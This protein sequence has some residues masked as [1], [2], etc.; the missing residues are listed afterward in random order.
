ME[1]YFLD[2]SFGVTCGPTEEF[3]SAVWSE[4]YYETGSFTVHMPKKFF[5]TAIDAEYLR[6]GFG[7]DGECL[8]GRI[9]N[10]RLTSSDGGE[11][12]ISG[13]MLE[14]LLGGRVMY[15][16]GEGSG[17]LGESVLDAVRSNLRSLPITLDDAG[18]TSS[19]DVSLDDECVISWKWD[20]M[21]QWLHDVLRPYGASY[22]VRLKK[23]A[24]KPVMT[25]VRGTNVTDAT[26]AYST[27]L[28]NVISLEYEKAY[29]HIRN[30][31]YVEGGDGT[32]AVVNKYSV[33][34]R[35]L[36][37]SA[38]ELTAEKYTDDDEYRRA[39]RQKGEE[40]L[41]KYPVSVTLT[42]S[43]T[44]GMPPYYGSD[45]RLGDICTVYDDELGIKLS[46]RMTSADVV[47]EGGAEGVYATFG[48]AVRWRDVLT[49]GLADG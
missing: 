39:L 28:G 48:E 13:V 26:L 30:Y 12:E 19:S 49:E 40:A 9:D 10:V 1:L 33:D 41:A 6:T 31:A 25:L 44:P 16:T 29:G 7:D 22:R 4:K 3:T 37:K 35:E 18:S 5:G 36:Y 32:V 2:R 47:C 34:R 27:S 15:G 21:A 8:C 43:A 14:G 17:K 24:E 42:V 23:G 46:M 38:S 45:C 20:N 11:C